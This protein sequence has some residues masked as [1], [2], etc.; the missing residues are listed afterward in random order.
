MNEE[1]PPESGLGPV[2]EGGA[3]E[4]ELARVQEELR[5]LA[6]QTMPAEVAARLD[7]AIVAEASAGT[8]G[9]TTDEIGAGQPAEQP[10]AQASVVPLV[11]RQRRASRVLM[12]GVAAVVLLFAGIV[13]LPGL[14]S[15]NSPDAFDAASSASPES[16]PSASSPPTQEVTSVLVASGT[17]YQATSL[18]SSA[19]DLVAEVTL[20]RANSEDTTRSDGPTPASGTDADEPAESQTTEPTPAE[21]SQAPLLPSAAPEQVSKW[22][23]CL[24]SIE[25]AR[26]SPVAIDVA[27]YE[28][29]PAFVVVRT[30]NDPQVHEVLVHLM[31]DCEAGITDIYESAEIPVDQDSAARDD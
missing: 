20:A 30:T 13:V 22:G 16:A 7:A 11:P 8:D 6:P 26:Q 19:S 10:A 14:Q 23:S 2:A 1:T 24:R 27:V 12:G 3:S 29:D 9:G 15:S 28:G 21:P 18:E 31:A 25:W 5:A 4:A 17:S